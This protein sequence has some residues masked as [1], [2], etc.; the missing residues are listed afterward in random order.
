MQQEILQRIIDAKYG[1]S[2]ENGQQIFLLFI[3][4]SIMCS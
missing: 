4:L 3:Y 1:P 2:N